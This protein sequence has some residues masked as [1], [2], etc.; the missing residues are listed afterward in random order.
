LTWKE[1]TRVHRVINRRSR[2]NKKPANPKA[3]RFDDFVAVSR[4]DPAARDQK[5]SSESGLMLNPGITAFMDPPP[6]VFPVRI[7]A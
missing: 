4:T 1:C 6:I 5:E 7:W 3:R 2:G